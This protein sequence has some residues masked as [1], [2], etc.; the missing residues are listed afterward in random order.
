MKKLLISLCFITA[1]S[2]CSIRVVAQENIPKLYPTGFMYNSGDNWGA[3][4]MFKMGFER[5][6]TD[7]LSG[8]G[9]FG[10]GV[11]RGGVRV[12]GFG[13]VRGGG[14]TMVLVEPQI[15]YYVLDNAPHGLYLGGF[16]KLG[17]ARNL[18]GAF[19]AV[20]PNVGYQYFLLENR[21]ALDGTVG[22]G[23]S[24]YAGTGNAAAGFHLQFSVGAGYAF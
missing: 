8:Q 4:Y 10:I 12:R 17:F 16:Y 21:L 14:L 15:N 18:G 9:N 5:V 13:R 11:Y 6:F 2:L 19:M 3:N 7:K 24:F 1:I 23:A 22:M 20:G